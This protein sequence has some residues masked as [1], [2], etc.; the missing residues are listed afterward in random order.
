MLSGSGVQ[1]PTASLP[2]S[3]VNSS[4]NAN[5]FTARQYF[6]PQPPLPGFAPRNLNLTGEL[7]RSGPMDVATTSPPELANNTLVTVDPIAFSPGK[8]LK[9]WH[10]A[11]HGLPA[12]LLRDIPV[13]AAKREHKRSVAPQLSRRMQRLRLTDDYDDY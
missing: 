9:S 11:G 4:S 1:T 8:R 6:A 2:Q 7:N 3:S 10:T 12:P 5:A 13:S